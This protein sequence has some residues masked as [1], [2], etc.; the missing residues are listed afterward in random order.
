MIMDP[1]HDNHLELPEHR[2][3]EFLARID[4]RCASII[5]H[6]NMLI[7]MV[8]FCGAMQITMLSLLIAKIC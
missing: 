1:K 7:A 5:R 3:D 2:D 8:A 4:Q 6:L